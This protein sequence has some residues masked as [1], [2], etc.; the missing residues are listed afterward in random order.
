MIFKPLLISLA[1]KAIDE[2]KQFG[3]DKGVYFGK[4]EGCN[5]FGTWRVRGNMLQC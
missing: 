5:H 2:E 1:S 4:D 3:L